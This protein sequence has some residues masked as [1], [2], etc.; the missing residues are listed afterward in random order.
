MRIVSWNVNGLR[1]V[2]R[3]GFLEWLKKEE[4]DILCLQ[5]VKANQDQLPWD[6]I[7]VSDYQFYL[8][9]AE[10]SGYSGVAVYSRVRPQKIEEKIGLERFDQEG[11]GLIFYFDQF[12]LFNL[13]LPHGG[14]QKENLAYKLRAYSYLLEKI[15]TFSEP[16]ILAGD[17]NVAHQEIDLA[18]PKENQ[19][20]IMFTPEER[21]QINKLLGLGFIDSFRYFYPDKTDAY[22]W[23]PYAFE[24][25]KKNLGWRIDYFFVSQKISTALRDSWIEKEVELSDHAPIGIELSF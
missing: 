12:I 19:N 4:P 14:R 10:K 5:E 23:W 11:R 3:K 2:Y 21:E 18:R 25:R 9:S 15:R 17:F 16:L 13:Y 6:L 7:V 8:N 1:A 20:N 24:A 22:T